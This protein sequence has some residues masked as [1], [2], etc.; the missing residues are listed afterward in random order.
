M[1]EEI[2][3][4]KRQNAGKLPNQSSMP[5]RSQT[6]TQCVSSGGQQNNN[7]QIQ[8]LESITKRRI[9]G[10]SVR[11]ADPSGNRRSANGGLLIPIATA[12]R[13]FLKIEKG[14][15]LKIDNLPLESLSFDRFNANNTGYYP[16]DIQL[17]NP[18][19]TLFIQSWATAPTGDI[20]FE[21][22]IYYVD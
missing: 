1:F 17:S 8:Q 12:Q 5:V 20:D 15:D 9:I 21:I 3:G 7:I 13:S 10:I 4:I 19:V 16:I 2:E 6:Y 22:T 11:Y 18:K 14:A